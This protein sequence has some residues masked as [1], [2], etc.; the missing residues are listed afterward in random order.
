MNLK[1]IMRKNFNDVDLIV[2]SG[3]A[4]PVECSF[5]CKS[6]VDGLQMDHHGEMSHL[7]SVAIRAYRDFFGRNTDKPFVVNHI[8]ADNT[9]AIAALSGLL[10]HPDNRYAE[11]LPENL[12]A[13]WQKDVSALAET[14]AIVDTDPIGRDILSMPFGEVLVTWNAMY[15][16]G[17]E[18]ELSALAAIQGWR[19]LLTNRNAAPFIK[20]AAELENS[21]VDNALLD[22]RE[23]GEKFG[24]V[25]L[26]NGSRVFGFN[27]WYQRRDDEDCPG[28]IDGWDNPVVISLVENAGNITIGCP[29][30]RVAEKLFGL[31]GLKNVFARLNTVFGLSGNNGFGGREVIG[32]SPRGR[33]MTQDELRLTARTVDQMIV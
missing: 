18:D 27:E 15:G 3:A 2:K 13:V 5:G 16:N 32:G 33:V 7:E 28:H 12:R 22:L 11:Q 4:V 8:D 21:R 25:M 26:I 30:Q 19:W 10:P 14:I 20:M 24:A 1:V 17:A 6:V 31:G 29:N 9:F 23:R